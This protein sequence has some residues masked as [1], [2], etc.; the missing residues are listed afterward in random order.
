MQ[1]PIAS[2]LYNYISSGM[3]KGFQRKR[4]SLV[5]SLPAEALDTFPAHWIINLLPLCLHPILDNSPCMV[6]EGQTEGEGEWETA[7]PALAPKLSLSLCC[8]H[9]CTWTHNALEWVTTIRGV[10]WPHA[11]ICQTPTRWPSETIKHPVA[12]GQL[13]VIQKCFHQ[14]QAP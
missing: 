10:S 14:R 5:S 12:L 3:F 9:T 2:P 4:P 8:W 11:H 1:W 6:K 7:Y 13:S